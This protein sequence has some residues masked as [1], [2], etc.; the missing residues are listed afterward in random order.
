MKNDKMSELFDE[1]GAFFA[2]STS[3]FEESRKEGV[4]YAGG[5]GG[6]I[7]PKDNFRKLYEGLEK[8][9]LE[10]IELDLSENS[11]K[12]IIRRELFNHECFYTGE[13]DECFSALEGY[14]TSLEEVQEVYDYIYKNEDL[15]L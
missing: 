11:M 7:C 10:K 12:E 4:I 14:P 1:L 15:N 5:Q 8:I 13:Y 6:L 9:R 3:Q 2:F